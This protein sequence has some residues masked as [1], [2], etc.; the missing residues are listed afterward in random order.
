MAYICFH[1]YPKN[2]NKIK[3]LYRQQVSFLNTIVYIFSKY[4]LTNL[5]DEQNVI[6]QNDIFLKMKEIF[7]L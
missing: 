3:S 7:T 1:G 6:F 4:V 2:A 5:M